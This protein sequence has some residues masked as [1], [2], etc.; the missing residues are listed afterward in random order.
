MN[1]LYPKKRQSKRR[2]KIFHIY[3]VFSREKSNFLEETKKVL[4]DNN[5]FQGHVEILDS[6]GE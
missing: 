4:L 6:G 1:T 2:N 3:Q 5:G